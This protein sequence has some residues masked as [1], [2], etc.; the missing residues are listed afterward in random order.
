MGKHIIGSC[1]K[2]FE[3]FLYFY[4]FHCIVIYYSQHRFYLSI[5]S[6]ILLMFVIIV[7]SMGVVLSP[8]NDVLY[9]EFL[10]HFHKKMKRDREKT[11]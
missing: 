5:K 4:I 8:Y 1:F 2:H 6:I 3:I 7:C 9:Y 11:P 10:F